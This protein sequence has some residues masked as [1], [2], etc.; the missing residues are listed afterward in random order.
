MTTGWQIVSM[1]AFYWRDCHR[2]DQSSTFTLV[3]PDFTCYRDTAACYNQNLL[4]FWWIL[5]KAVIKLSSVKFP[6]SAKEPL[7]GDHSASIFYYFPIS[8]KEPLLGD[9]SASL[10]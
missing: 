8:A 6:I 5:P 10:R 7:L 4:L 2:V 9:H 1:I 3:I